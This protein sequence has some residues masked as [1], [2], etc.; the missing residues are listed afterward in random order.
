MKPFQSSF[1]HFAIHT[2]FHF[3]TAIFIIIIICNFVIILITM[4]GMHFILHHASFNAWN[5]NDQ[6]NSQTK[7]IGSINCISYALQ[8][9]L[10]AC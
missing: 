10:T 2:L 1:A 9:M 5:A 6:V 4:H 3:L 8:N 7:E